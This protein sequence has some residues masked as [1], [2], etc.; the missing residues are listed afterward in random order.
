M[1]LKNM[2]KLFLIAII[3]MGILNFSYADT[4][5]TVGPN[6]A[7][8]TAQN[9]LNS[10]NLPYSAIT[11]NW[12]AWK[13]KVKDVKTGVEK[14]IPVD[15]AK[16]DSPDFGGP[17]KYKGVSGYNTTWTVQIN[18]KNGK[19][20]GKIYIDAE[21]GKI[22]K[23]SID[24]V[25]QAS[26]P[27]ASTNAVSVVNGDSSANQNSQGS[28]GHNTGVIYSILLLISTICAGYFTYNRL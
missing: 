19:N 15:E 28:S 23:T 26:K 3:V 21:N 25:S 16:K 18:N 27:T 9:Y 24:P 11:P 4:G 14:W 2:F 6:Q 1:A 8:N 7:K 17:G 12:D 13:A 10:H 22:L 5:P 20:V